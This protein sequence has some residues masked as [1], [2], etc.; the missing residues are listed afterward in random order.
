MIVD[1]WVNLFPEA[2]ASKWA[3]KDEQKGVLQLFG[4]DLAKGP[5]VEGLV[6]AMDDAGIDLGVLTA[7]LSDPERAHRIGGYAAED[8]LAI[9]ERAPRPL[10]RVGHRRPGRQAAAQLRARAR[11]GRST[12]RRR[13][14][15]GH[16]ARRAV[17]A[18]PPPLLPRVRHVR[19]ARASRCRSTSASPARRCARAAR[20]RCCSRTCSS[21]SPASPSSAPTWATPTRR[22]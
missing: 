15:A 19:G 21:T 7:G 9:A 4:D 16:A 10:P 13:A 8:F 1:G 5:T 14:G 20:T 11:A 6:A 22:C 12:T 3:A 17:R 18:E 2:F